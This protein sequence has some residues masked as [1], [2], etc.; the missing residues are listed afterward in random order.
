MGG[1]EVVLFVLFGFPVTVA[2]AFTFGAG[3]FT[4]SLAAYKLIERWMTRKRRRLDMLREYLDR[5][6]KDITG[7][8]P[9]VLNG[10][11]LSE[12]AY[13]SEKKLDVGAEIDRAIDLLDRGYPQAAAGKLAELEKRLLTD[14]PMLRKR[15]DDL[16]LHTRSV[17]IFL[18]A[19][20][21][22][23]DKPDLGLEHIDKALND[24]GSDLDA[25]KYK[26]LLLLKKGE[27][28]NADR[29]FERLRQRAN[30]QGNACYRADAHLGI[31]T[32]KFKRGAANF[33]GAAQS[34]TTALS[35]INAV[36]TADQDHF[37]FAEI[38]HLQ[39]DIYAST[40]WSG[41][42]GA[43]ALESYRRAKDALN[44][45]PNRRKVMESKIKDIDT[46]MGGL[47]PPPSN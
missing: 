36:A 34:L 43:K 11:R 16:K 9:T 10:I 6:E 18:G 44:L 30:G 13:L 47:Q 40:G 21:D 1:A 15:A 29:F 39:G 8:R 37:T 32:V 23:E 25:L 31:A 4:V 22:R 14:E 7:R 5:E 2:H 33:D 24:D 26:A 46:K 12:H 42:D 45:I 28:D 27:L 41:T 17:R 3:V 20:A 38:Y 35:N 19:L